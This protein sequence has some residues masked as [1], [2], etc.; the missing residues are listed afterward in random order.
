MKV[1]DK[2][3]VVTGAGSGMGRELTLELIR[4]GAKVAAVDMRPE[5]LE[6]TK[7]LA[8]AIGGQIAN[9]S[10]LSNWPRVVRKVGCF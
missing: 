7:N 6:E 9:A 4:K 2:V 3:V 5:T 1:Q 10:I 8:N